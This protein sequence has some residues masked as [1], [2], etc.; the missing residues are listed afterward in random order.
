MERQL[1]RRTA[2]GLAFGGVLAAAGCASSSNASSGSGS[3]TPITV[4][5]DW[6]PDTNHTGVYVAQQ[7]GYYSKRGID[8][9]IIPYGSTAPET[10]INR[11]TADFGFSYQAGTAYAQAAGDDVVGVFAQ[12]QRGLYVIAYAADNKA[13]ETPKNFDGLTYAGFGTPDEKPELEY[14]MKKAGGTGK[15]TEV[16]LN[17]DAYDAVYNGQAQFTIAQISWECIEGKLIGKP[18]KWFEPT[19][20]G[21]P[22]S[23]STL[24]SSSQKFLTKNPALARNFLAATAEGYQ[25]AATNPH[26]AGGLLIQANPGVFAQTALVYDSEALLKAD[27]YMTTASGQVGTQSASKWE[28]YGEFLYSNKLLTDSSG[29]PLTSKPD[30]ADYYTNA[31]LPAADQ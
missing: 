22:D 24:I 20:Y 16:V 6:T 3:G 4:A 2:I 18:L 12:Y 7:L 27:G 29:N 5:L 8:L 1:S 31:Y 11:G 21:F 15:F 19:A 30:W 17:T 28:E 23:Y 14:I 25:Y 13:I 10:L 26:A 9:K